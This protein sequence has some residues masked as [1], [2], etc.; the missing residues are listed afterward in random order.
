MLD[1]QQ[2]EVEHPKEPDGYTL[3][4]RNGGRFEIQHSLDREDSTVESTSNV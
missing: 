4:N 1:P 3:V 2:L